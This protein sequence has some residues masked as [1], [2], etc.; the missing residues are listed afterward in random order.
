MFRDG[1]KVSDVVVLQKT[2]LRGSNATFLG[3]FADEVDDLRLLR[4]KSLK[5]T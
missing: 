1:W 3:L 2:Y 4:D 5:T